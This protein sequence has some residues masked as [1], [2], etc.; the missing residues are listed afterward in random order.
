MN[1]Q[2]VLGIELLTAAQA[3]ELRWPHKSSPVL[4]EL[5]NS[6][7]KEIAFMAEDEVLGEKMLAAEKFLKRAPVL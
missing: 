4:E 2:R 6:L 5:L 1:V 3:L 7:R